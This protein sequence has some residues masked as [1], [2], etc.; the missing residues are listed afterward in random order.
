MR[1]ALPAEMGCLPLLFILAICA[2]VCTLPLLFHHS[3]PLSHD[4]VFHMFLA[5]EF[6]HNVDAGV[7]LPRWVQGAA[8]G[9]GS[10]IF[11]FYSP[12][13][14][15]LAAL[16]RSAFP[17]LVTA[18]IIAAWL[19][20]F[21]SGVAM[22]FLVRE[23]VSTKTAPVAA[24]LYLLLPFHTAELYV[25]GAF[26]GLFAYVWYPLVLL[27]LLRFWQKRSCSRD[28]CLLAFSFAGL[29]MTHLVSAFMMGLVVAGVLLA[30]AVR[31]E[32]A[33][34][35]RGMAGMLWGL[36]L[37]AVY[38]VPAIM[39]RPWVHIS[40]L[41]VGPTGRYG[42]NFLFQHLSSAFSPFNWFLHAVVVLEVVIAFLWV[43]L[44]RDDKGGPPLVTRFFL[45]LFAM[46]ILLTTPLS[47]PLAV[48]IPALDNLQFP[49]RWIAPSESLV[50]VLIAGA[51]TAPRR[52]G[53]RNLLLLLPALL[54]VLV[55]FRAPML[56]QDF[57]ERVSKPHELAR[58][59]DPVVEYIPRTVTEWRGLPFVEADAVRGG[60]T[61]KVLRWR[62]Q[63]RV[64]ETESLHPLQLRLPLFYYP[65]WTVTVNNRPAPVKLEAGSGVI[66]VD[67]PAGPNLVRFCFEE[68]SLRAIARRLSL[69]AFFLL[70]VW[71]VAEVVWR[72]W[73]QPWK[74][75]R[76]ELQAS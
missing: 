61:L 51:L 45:P 52:A 24:C 67:I 12:L 64:I 13:A 32:R 56:R 30:L 71:L 10:P 57:L 31:R 21:F 40:Y 33:A 2:T 68:T 35:M 16:V 70:T 53:G 69:L 50:A 6:Q 72:R 23:T 66:L 38:L 58:I 43:R 39:E 29:V 5:D 75:M 47:R 63:E 11:L 37:A 18:L 25:R 74:Q 7:F 65:G 46:L 55:I 34:A 73:I 76:K 42:D 14:Y 3:L 44:V 36:A 49:W 41:M 9:Y 1:G 48:L 26:A 15:L 62:P 17:D 8:G 54:G 27:F 20:F 60:K 28:I 19:A 59:M 22:Y 4:I